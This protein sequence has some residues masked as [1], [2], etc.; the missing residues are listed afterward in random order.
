LDD[1][2]GG[3]GPPRI[4]VSVFWLWVQFVAQLERGGDNIARVN[5]DDVA[6]SLYP[7]CEAPGW[8]AQFP[9]TTEPVPVV[10]LLFNA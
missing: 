7:P 9:G 3:T 4:A 10:H 1:A 8:L 6:H 2:C 5:Q